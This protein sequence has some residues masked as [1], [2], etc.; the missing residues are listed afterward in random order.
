VLERRSG[1]EVR[2]GRRAIA[3]TDESV[4]RNRR[5]RLKRCRKRYGVASAMIGEGD[6]VQWTGGK[7]RGSANRLRDHDRKLQRDGEKE[8]CSL[9]GGR[10]SGRRQMMWSSGQWPVA[11]SSPRKGIITGTRYDGDGARI[12]NFA[13]EAD[14]LDS[15]TSMLHMM[16]RMGNEIRNTRSNPYYASSR[17]TAQGF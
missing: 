17:Q 10:E 8:E 2:L 7:E 9:E 15:S 4:E 11:V 1:G 3:A 12:T 6:L 16:Q 13:S 14:C 5:R